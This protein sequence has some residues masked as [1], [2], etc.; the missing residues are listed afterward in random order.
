MDF[1]GPH[2]IA[3]KYT[4]RDVLL[5]EGDRLTQLYLSDVT[6][7][8]RT[9]EA[10]LSYEGENYSSPILGNPISFE[11]ATRRMTLEDTRL[12]EKRWLK[13]WSRALE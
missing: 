8:M 12:V 3:F 9:N 1:N 5:S 7:D 6:L 4:G 2:A 10:L 13:K 11:E